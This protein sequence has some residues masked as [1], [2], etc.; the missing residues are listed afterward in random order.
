M[1]KRLKTTA[2]ALAFAAAG[3]AAATAQAQD[4]KFLTM[5]SNPPG[6]TVGQFMIA[7]TQVV[8]KNLPIEIQ[9]STG[10][11]STK[12]AVDAALQKVDLYT[13]APTIN[14]YMQNKAA[15][16]SK[17][18]NAP[19]LNKNLRGLINYPLGPYQIVTYADS[20]IEKLEDI[21]GRKVFLGPPAGA[22][23]KVMKDVVEAVTGL[24]PDEGYEAMRYDWSSAETAFLD[25]QMDVYIVPTSIP[26]PQI[27]QFAL[28]RPIR[29][30]GIPQDKFEH[31][32]IKAALQYP[33]RTI[34]DIPP[35]SYENQ[36]NTESVNTIGSWVGIQTQ[37]WLDEQL[38][39][40]MVRVFFE[41][42]DE[43]HQTAPWM[44][45]ITLQTALNEMNVPLHAGAYRFYKEQGL[46][47]PEELVPPQG[48]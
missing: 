35:G 16:Y 15:M 22:A 44:K 32:L 5:D 8:Q 48:E 20:G 33:G 36:V 6:T 17:V 31:D 10:K 27:Q 1:L 29:I 2:W 19:E 13:G 24:V 21:K 18:E 37:K 43:V 9:M 47:I 28:V 41:H 14:W 45:I 25:G 23:T 38:A 4:K 12:S 7:F 40:D 30:L 42:L 39:Y 26:S 46:E 34:W 3:L 11:P